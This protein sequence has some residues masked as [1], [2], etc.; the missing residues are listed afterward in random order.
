MNK[1]RYANFGHIAPLFQIYEAIKLYDSE[2][3]LSI[4]RDF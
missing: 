2:Q 1:L 4:S 3:S